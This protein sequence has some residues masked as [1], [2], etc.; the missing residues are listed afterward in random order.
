MIVHFPIG[1]IERKGGHVFGQFYSELVAPFKTAKVIPFENK[2]YESLA[3]D[4][5]LADA[6]GH[7]SGA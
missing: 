6:L 1:S 4:P 5:S 7:A 3:V 2:G